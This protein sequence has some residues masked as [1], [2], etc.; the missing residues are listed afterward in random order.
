VQNISKL[1][2]LVSETFENSHS[3]VIKQEHP[4]SS[5]SSSEDLVKLVE[6][7]RRKTKEDDSLCI[8][9]NPQKSHKVGNL[10]WTTEEMRNKYLAFRDIVFINKRV[11][12]NRF[13]MPMFLIYVVTSEGFNHLVGFCLLDKDEESCYKWALERFAEYMAGKAPKMVIIERQM[14]LCKEVKDVFEKTT[15]LFDPWHLHK[16]LLKQFENMEDANLKELIEL[17]LEQNVKI[18]E[19]KLEK[20]KKGKYEEQYI[21]TL[22]EKLVGEKELWSLAYHKTHFTGGVCV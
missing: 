15:V 9:K 22:V 12:R 13:G 6:L 10:F 11:S 16:A 19:E 14:A 2:E 1:N 8:T 17:P 7:L 4:D 3:K 5:D 18:V 21:Q 20:I